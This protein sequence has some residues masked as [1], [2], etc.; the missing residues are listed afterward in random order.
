MFTHA[1]M[2]AMHSERILVFE[3]PDS[4]LRKASVGHVGNLMVRTH[5][6]CMPVHMHG[7]H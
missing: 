6:G 5:G 2:Q 1:P 7:V 3:P 4:K